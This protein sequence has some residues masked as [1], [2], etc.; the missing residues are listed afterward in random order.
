MCSV[1]QSQKWRT[2]SRKWPLVRMS[3]CIQ[4]RLGYHHEAREHNTTTSSIVMVYQVVHRLRHV[5]VLLLYASNSW[6][7]EP[8]TVFADKQTIR[9]FLC[10]SRS[11]VCSNQNN[12][13]GGARRG[14]ELP[15]QA[16]LRREGEQACRSTVGTVWARA[17][18]SYWYFEVGNSRWP[19][20]NVDNGWKTRVCVI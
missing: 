10:P 17:L 2:N 16:I 7:R 5:C 20:T 1:Y 4:Y 19:R 14:Q 6:K 13:D 3:T 9:P 18:G 15:H 12:L 11:P 8:H